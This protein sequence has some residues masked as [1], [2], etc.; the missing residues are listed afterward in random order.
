MVIFHSYVKLL[1]G[2]SAYQSVH[3]WKISQYP[4]LMKYVYDIHVKSAILYMETLTISMA[5]LKFAN[6]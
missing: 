4:W 1:E 2:M 5:I 6:C 3:L